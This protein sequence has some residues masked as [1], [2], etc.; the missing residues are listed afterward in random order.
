MTP[1][2][3]PHLCVVCSAPIPG[4]LTRAEALEKGAAVEIEG[5]TYYRCI[6][7][8]AHDEVI[9]AINRT[10]AFTNAGGAKP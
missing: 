8:H 1:R 6:G 5:K 2:I 4:N 10:P 9:A 7:R 3:E